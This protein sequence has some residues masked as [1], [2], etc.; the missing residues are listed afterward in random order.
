MRR[1]RRT[2]ARLGAVVAL[3]LLLT[4]VAAFVLPQ[5]ASATSVCGVGH[6]G[7]RVAGTAECTVRVAGKQRSYL[8]S[9]PPSDQPAPLV[10]AFHGLFQTARVFAGQTGLV[11]ATRNAGLVLALP[12][13]DG[14]AFNDGRL[15]ATGP[16]DDAFTLALVDELVA[17]KVVDRRRVVVAGFSNGAGMAMSVAC[18]HPQAVAAL[19][20]VDGSLMDGVGAPRPTAPV[21]AV[22]VHGTADKVQPWEGRPAKG[23]MLPAYI[24]VPATVAAWASA[25]GGGPAVVDR[26]PGSLGRGP[27]EV[28]T[29]SPGPSGV[30][31]VSYVISGMGHVWPVSESDNLDA[32]TLLVH[33]AASVAPLPQSRGAARVDPVALSRAVLLRH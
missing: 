27:V 8:L 23:P 6:R 7:A 32:T 30:G 4:G 9:V 12:E 29:W 2:R 14:P 18:A 25:A 11:S 16:Q 20:S 3:A 21:R 33:T 1:P 10:V 28:S 24:P 19:V 22:L 5:G 31:V 26:L 17:A 15:G 13:S